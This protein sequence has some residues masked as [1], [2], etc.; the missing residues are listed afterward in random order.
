MEITIEKLTK[1][2]ESP[3]DDRVLTGSRISKINPVAAAG[4]E[5]YLRE[6]SNSPI[7]HKMSLMPHVSLRARKR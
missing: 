6:Q 7:D 2:W 1:V 4:L 5:R 3:D